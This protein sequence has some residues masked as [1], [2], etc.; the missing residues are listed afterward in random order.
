MKRLLMRNSDK[1]LFTLIELLV[2]IAIIAIL[3]AIILP[4]LKGV[5]EQ[6]NKTFC[7]GNMKQIGGALYMYLDDA[8]GFLVYGGTSSY[9]YASMLGP[10]LN[11]TKRSG[12]GWSK[13]STVFQCTSAPPSFDYS[14]A[15]NE[16]SGY[17]N[18]SK[19]Y[20]RV[21]T[22]FTNLSGI[23]YLAE[24][25]NRVSFNDVHLEYFDPRHNASGNCVFLDGHVTSKTL[26][27]PSD[28]KE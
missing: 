13:C 22:D 12:I 17:T 23:V 19:P 6:G 16:W 15:Q 28:L 10:Y 4:A 27:S 26:I 25:D 2:V 18:I 8:N 24:G 5:K 7:A 3:M 9:C 14:Y 21:F 1:S 20:R 11:V